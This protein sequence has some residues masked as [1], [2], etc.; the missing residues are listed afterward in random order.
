MGRLA[1]SGIIRLDDTDRI[2]RDLNEENVQ[3]IFKRCL[4]NENNRHRQVS[5]RSFLFLKELG[6][7]VS[8]DKIYFDKNTIIANRKNIEYLFGQL[9]PIHNSKKTSISLE[10]F[11]KKY[12]KENW[13]ANGAV[14]LELLFLGA[15]DDIDLIAP[16]NP[17]K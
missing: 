9:Q 6:Y 13:T 1:R 2:V 7:D 14:L 5:T 16:F 12:T 15:C 10:D 17:K 4:I 11:C 3:E 8:K